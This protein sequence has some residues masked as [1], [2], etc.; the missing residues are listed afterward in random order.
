[1]PKIVI[2]ED[3]ARRSSAFREAAKELQNIEVLIFDS[4]HIICDWLTRHLA[5]VCLISLDCDLDSTNHLDDSCGSGED[6]VEF[7]TKQTIRVPVIIHSSNAMRGPA[8]HLE[9]T[10]AG[11]PDVHVAPFRDGSQWLADIAKWIAARQ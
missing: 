10:M 6:V 7:L 4:A 3:D 11:F 8:M 1:M 5:E 9:L 2:L